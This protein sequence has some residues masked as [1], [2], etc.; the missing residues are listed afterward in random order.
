MT[1]SA[2]KY[3]AIVPAAGVG[4]RFSADIP[5][6]FHQ[7]NGALVA[8]HTLSRL[9]SL[10]VIRAIVAPC[11]VGSGYWTKV[12]AAADP[13]VK[14]VAGGKQR[15]DS[16][17]N[18]LIALQEYAADQDWVLV[19]DMARPCVTAANIAKLIAELDGH[20]VGGILAAPI[21]DTLKVVAADKRI[22]STVNRAEYR[23]AQTPQMFRFGL[24]K[25]S[26]QAMLDQQ[27]LPT[28]EASAIEFAGFSAQVVEGRQDNIKITR[29]ED[30][31]IAE[32]IMKNQEAES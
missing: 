2:P 14:L 18:G 25:S 10:P 22:L 13:R 4:Q 16:V 1:D 17:M 26:I 7:L 32:A 23:A 3:W 30:L 6:Q 11:E 20:S 24:L 15:A 27:K 31:A 19:H 8:Q 21:N 9:L 5:K 29:R 28:D 12:P